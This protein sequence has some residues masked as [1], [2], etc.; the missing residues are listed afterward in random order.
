MSDERGF[1][2]PFVMFVFLAV[3][4]VVGVGVFVSISAQGG[5]VRDQGTK[6][7]LSAAEAG[8]TQ[9][10]FNYNGG[11]TTTAA[12]PCLVPVSGTVQ[13]QTPPVG[14]GG[15]CNATSPQVSGAGG[16]GTFSYRVC[17]S[18]TL[19]PCQGSGTIEIVATGTYNGV[20]RRVDVIAKSASGQAVFGTAGVQSQT[21]LLLDSN[22]EVHSGSMSGGSTTLAS[23]STKLC[24][25]ASVGVAGSLTSAGGGYY[26]N[27]D[28][29]SPLAYS[30]AAHMDFVLPPVNQG[31]AAT[32]NDNARITNAISGT[33]SPADLI[34]GSTSNIT[35]NPSTRQL[36]LTGQKTTLTLTG[37]TYSLCKLTMQQN[38]TIYVAPGQAVRI[39]F[40]SPEHCGPLPPYNA[41]NS[42]TQKATSQLWMESNTRISASSGNAIALNVAILFVGSSTVPTGVLMSSNSDSN[43]VCV[44]NFVIY[45]PL[46]AIELN[47]NSTYCGAIAGKSVHLDQ[48]A[49]FYTSDAVKTFFL[50][51]TAPHYVTQRFVDCDT[52]AVSPP[53]ANC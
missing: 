35:W 22:A 11:F 53:N 31:N 8:I 36:S 12:F 30:S 4:A 14:G 27:S 51:A 50:T 37:K 33:A 25:P 48:N 34:G 2:L 9:A 52:T 26:A 40:D 44:Q 28:C 42:T 46:T 32:V 41:T 24:G 17:P 16:L 21:N 45:A 23:S 7:A 3:F 19:N 18:T 6:S 39:Y 43:A 13:A 20:T 15:W 49:R 47:S 1:A 29:T 5:T 10:M 38:S